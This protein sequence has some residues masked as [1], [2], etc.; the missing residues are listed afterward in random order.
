MFMDWN[1][2]SWWVND[3]IM[4]SLTRLFDCQITFL[5]LIHK[6]IFISFLTALMLEIW[7]Y[8]HDSS[9]QPVN[10]KKKNGIISNLINIPHKMLEFL[11]LNKKK[12]LYLNLASGNK[13]IINR[14]CAHTMFVAHSL[15]SYFSF[16][17]YHCLC[18]YDEHRFKYESEENFFPKKMRGEDESKENRKSVELICATN[19]Y[20]I[21]S[22]YILIFI[23][24]SSYCHHFEFLF[25]I[26]F[27][28]QQIEM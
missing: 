27:R 19:S 11:S 28:M 1:L 10:K 3:W 4:K 14:I 9:F 26:F 12:V 16:Y 5:F 2:I 20:K 15:C 22:V 18:T 8:I 6:I 21:F 23:Y 24:V 25:Y 17:Y 7:W 13:K